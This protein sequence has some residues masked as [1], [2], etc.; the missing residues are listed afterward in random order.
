MFLKKDFVFVRHGQT[1][2]NLST[3]KMD[4]GDISLNATGRMQALKIA[5]I[6]QNYAFQTIC[7]SPLKRAKETKDLLI[8]G[9]DHQ[10]ILDLG[11]CTSDIWNS[12]IHL[13]TDAF[14]KGPI[15]VRDFLNRVKDGM[16]Q[17]L[18][19]PG[20][21]L[22]VAHGGT[23]WAICYWL[24]IENHNWIIDNCQPVHFFCTQNPDKW[25]ARLL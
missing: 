14:K 15:I 23:H 10:E 8:S 9:K 17:A 1:N 5:P 6:I 4:H 11:E 22:I 2:H 13:D 12:M 21:T 20:P 3:Y 25:T 18:K 24:N 19:Y 7:C 16:N